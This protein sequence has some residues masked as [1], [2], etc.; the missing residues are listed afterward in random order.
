MPMRTALPLP[1][2]GL[3]AITRSCGMRSAASR[4][5]SAT[6]PSFEPSSTTTISQVPG[7]AARNCAVASSVGVMRSSSL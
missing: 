6:V 2:L 3:D 7:W 4:S 1:R 5:H